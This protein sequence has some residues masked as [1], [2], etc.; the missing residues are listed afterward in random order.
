MFRLLKRSHS[1]SP[2]PRSA[3]PRSR[4]PSASASGG[5]LPQ[6]DL[7]KFGAGCRHLF[8][9]PPTSDGGSS[10]NTPGQKRSHSGRSLHIRGRCTASSTF[11]VS[12]KAS[13]IIWGGRVVSAAP[14]RCTVSIARSGPETSSLQ[15]AVQPHLVSAVQSGAHKKSRAPEPRQGA[16][17]HLHTP[18]PHPRLIKSTTTLSC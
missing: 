6:T 17:S 12:I 1:N 18:V 14:S 7:P 4:L 3:S 16:G 8:C 13:V 2:R 9:A 11:N 10:P 15:R 5:L